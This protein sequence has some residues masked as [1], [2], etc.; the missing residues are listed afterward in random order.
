[1][2]LVRIKTF[3]EVKGDFRGSLDCHSTSSMYP[4]GFPLWVCVPGRINKPIDNVFAHKNLVL[5][6][7]QP[8][9]CKQNLQLAFYWLRRNSYIDRDD[10]RTWWFELHP[11]FAA[12]RKSPWLQFPRRD[13]KR[14]TIAKVTPRNSLLAVNYVPGNQSDNPK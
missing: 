11:L 8:K 10:C 2:K 14:Q 12:I 4:K 1:M 13:V 6:I 9:W 7:T 3:T 5:V